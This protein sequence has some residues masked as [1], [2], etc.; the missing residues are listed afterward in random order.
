MKYILDTNICI[1]IIKNNPITVVEKFKQLTP[2]DIGISSVTLAELQ[3]G[4]EKSQHQE[5]NRKALQHFILPLEILPFDENAAACY[6]NLRTQLEKKGQP[7]GCMDLMI[8]AHVLSLK[9]TLV[10]NNLKEFTKVSHLLLE[11]WI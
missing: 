1:Y 8:A 7:I 10:A 2:N 5:K 4:V 9:L 11:N 6:G 3:Y